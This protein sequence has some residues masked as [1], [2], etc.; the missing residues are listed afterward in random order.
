MF[1]SE[2]V[3]ESEKAR[4]YEEMQALGGL[5]FDVTTTE[6]GW[7]AQCQEIPAIIAGN[8]NPTPSTVEI[9]TEIRLAIFAAFDIK[10]EKAEIESPISEQFSYRIAFQ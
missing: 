1:G 8:T 10:P 4:L 3:S 2:R 5:T 9:E 6:E 7:T